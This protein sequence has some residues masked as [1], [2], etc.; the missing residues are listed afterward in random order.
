MIDTGLA[1]VGALGFVGLQVKMWKFGSALLLDM[2][3]P[4]KYLESTVYWVNIFD[5]T[6]WD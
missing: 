5:R 1:S 6:A 4:Q 2:R 3:E